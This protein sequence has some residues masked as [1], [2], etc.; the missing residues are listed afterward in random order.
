MGRLDFLFFL[1][2]I[3]TWAVFLTGAETVQ[4]TL[5][6]VYRHPRRLT[7]RANTTFKRNM[8]IKAHQLDIGFARG[9]LAW[10]GAE[11]KTLHRCPFYMVRGRPAA[12]CSC[13]RSI[14]AINYSRTATSLPQPLTP[15]P[16]LGKS[17]MWVM[18]RTWEP[19][20]FR[21]LPS[22]VREICQGNYR[23]AASLN[24]DG[25]SMNCIVGV[26]LKDLR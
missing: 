6:G 5:R 3:V 13:G 25:I 4:W 9:P 26:Q 15:C 21:V 20:V 22:M 16:Q 1:S 8:P 14:L 7:D 11:E 17:L 2:T 24:E 10:A 23:K 12:T 19:E 18:P